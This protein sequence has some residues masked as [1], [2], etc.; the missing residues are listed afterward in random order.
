MTNLIE[1]VFL[2]HCCVTVEDVQHTFPTLCEDIPNW[3]KLDQSVFYQ[4]LTIQL[5]H[6]LIEKEEGNLE[7]TQLPC[8]PVYQCKKHNTRTHVHLLPP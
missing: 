2:L 5:H 7:N 8:G 1:P 4:Q 6:L 3:R